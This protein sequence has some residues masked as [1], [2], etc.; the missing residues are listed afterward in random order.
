M[1][2]KIQKKFFVFQTI[3]FELEVP[4]SLN[5]EQDTCHRQ[6]MVLRKTPKI[7]PNT[8]RDIFQINFPRND[9]NAW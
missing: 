3:A 6:S 8:R 5:I 9:E 7:L 2:Q 4:N 1:E